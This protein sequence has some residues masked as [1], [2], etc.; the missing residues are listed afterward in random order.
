LRV[1]LSLF[2]GIRKQFTQCVTRTTVLIDLPRVD[3]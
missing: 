3:C 2:R 1:A